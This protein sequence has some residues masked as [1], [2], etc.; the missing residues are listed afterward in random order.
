MKW[1]RYPFV[2][3]FSMCG[4]VMKAGTPADDFCSMRN[5]SYQAGEQLTF[6]VYYAVAGIYVNAGTALFSNDLER[7]NGKPVYH[8]TGDGKTNSSYDWIYT[9]RDKYESYI[10]TATMMP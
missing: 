6:T 8:V 1:F 10:D 2:L 7:L 9:V 3:V 5:T 4:M